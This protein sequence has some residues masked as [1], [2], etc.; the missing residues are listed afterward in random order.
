MTADMAFECLLVTHDQGV[1]GTLSRILRDL[2]ISTDV[3]LSSS[4]ALNL[5]AKSS[6]DL[7]VI[8]WED[9]SSELLD[10]IWKS[11][12][13]QKL[14]V[15]AISSR[16]RCLPGVHV[17]IKKPLT[18]ESGRKSLKVAYSRMLLD[19]RRHARYVLMAPVIVT[20][21]R[22]RNV[23][24]TVTDIGEGGIGLRGKEEFSIG[25]AL[26]FRFL[27]PGASREIYIQ[28]R[29]LW[30][31]DFGRVGCEFLRIPPVDLDIL[32]DWLKHKVRVKK[33]LTQI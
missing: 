2:S 26:S 1:F 15:V 9:A 33:P 27:L 25:D 13:W 29:I 21:D 30:T 7:I 12:I 16:E 6:A 20:D 31:R 23:A 17:V 32:H 5:L 4:K 19:Y 10:Q 11:G 24:A 8:D 22:N 14:T 28:A 3:C 18:D